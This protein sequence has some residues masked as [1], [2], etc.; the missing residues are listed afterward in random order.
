MHL[1]WSQNATSRTVLGCEG[2]IVS[3]SSCRSSC[4]FQMSMCVRLSC[5]RTMSECEWQ[6]IAYFCLPRRTNVNS[7]LI[8]TF[9]FYLEFRQSSTESKVWEVLRYRGVK[10]VQ[11]R[12]STLCLWLTYHSFISWALLCYCWTNCLRCRES[13]NQPKTNCI[14][15][16]KIG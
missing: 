11:N 12:D 3:R 7:K 1:K 2:N 6:C 4:P 13:L 5:S 15:K 9:S 16:Y 14:W 10:S 8:L